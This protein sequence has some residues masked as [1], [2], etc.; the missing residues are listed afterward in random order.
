MT[1]LNYVLGD[2]AGACVLGSALLVIT[3]ATIAAIVDLPLRGLHD[4][5]AA[6]PARLGPLL[7]SRLFF[8]VGLPAS[9]LVFLSAAFQ[10][11][12]ASTPL[13]TNSSGLI[14]FITINAAFFLGVLAWGFASPLSRHWGLGLGAFGLGLAVLFPLLAVILS[15]DFGAFGTLA[16][17]GERLLFAAAVGAILC[18]FGAC[19]AAILSMLAYIAGG[20]AELV[21]QHR[22]HS[23]W[24]AGNSDRQHWQPLDARRW[25]NPR[26][27]GAAR[28]RRGL[29]ERDTAERQHTG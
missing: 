6:P 23:A 18:S 11:Y 12:L 5:H 2:R 29:R 25:S 20:T 1:L 19:L 15:L 21:S 7:P 27:R 22:Y 24:S 16:D 26:R 4:A 14:F 17:A 28:T 8:V 3:L 13:R 9:L 10:A